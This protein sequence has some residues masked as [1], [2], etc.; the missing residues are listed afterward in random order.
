MSIE[1]GKLYHNIGS[2]H[3]YYKDLT[4]LRQCVDEISRR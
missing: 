3:A 2:L 1:Y 4:T